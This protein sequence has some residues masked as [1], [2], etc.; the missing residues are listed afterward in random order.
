MRKRDIVLLTCGFVIASL[1]FSVTVLASDA[2]SKNLTVYFLPLKYY[3]DTVKKDP[4]AD[5]TG[6]IYEGTTY[7]P[8]GF[9][10]ESLGKDVV[11][12]GTSYSIYVGKQR[13]GTVTRLTSLEPVLYRDDSKYS[14]TRWTRAQ[15]APTV[16]QRGFTDALTAK[17]G[18]TNYC[19]YALNAKYSK[20][21]GYWGM[22]DANK[23]VASNFALIV[24]DQDG[25]TL[26]QGPPTSGGKDPVSF[27]V[28]V[29]GVIRMSLEC[30][31]VSDDAWFDNYDASVVIGDPMLI[32]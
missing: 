1:L 22:A 7:V 4:P 8:L 20:F 30:A 9:V 16:D 12:D 17:G 3:F 2:V 5:K 32:W 14:Q 26:Y 28:D 10:C 23:N 13:T 21:E 11:W 31:R 6:F 29:R 27:S 18:A 19:E 25:K 24:K 15:P